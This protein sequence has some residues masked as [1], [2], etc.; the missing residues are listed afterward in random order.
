M[1]NQIVINEQ[2]K[3]QLINTVKYLKQIK[4][5]VLNIN[6]ELFNQRK[7]EHTD[8]KFVNISWD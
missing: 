4:K 3:Y 5:K 2:N 1:N 6:L 7:F 8:K